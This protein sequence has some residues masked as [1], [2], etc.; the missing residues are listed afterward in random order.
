MQNK[1]NDLMTLVDIDN[2][3]LK[4]SLDYCA[5]NIENAKGFPNLLSLFEIILNNNQKI[6]KLIDVIDLTLPPSQR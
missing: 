1:L 3:L 5:Y 4:I 6:K 2:N